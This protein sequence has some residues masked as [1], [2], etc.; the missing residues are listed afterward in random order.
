MNHRPVRFLSGASWCAALSAVVLSACSPSR[1]LERGEVSVTLTEDGRLEVRRAGVLVASTHA[2]GPSVEGDD[3]REGAAYAGF[4]AG[5]TEYRKV[6]EVYGFYDF[7]EEFSPWSRLVP[8]EVSARGDRLT[9]AFQQGGKGEASI[10][11]DGTVHLSWSVPEGLGDRLAMSFTCDDGERFF[12]LGAQVSAEH[13]GWRVPIWTSEQGIGKADRGRPHAFGIAGA[14]YDSYAPIPFALT[15]RPLGMWLESNHRSEFELCEEGRAIRIEATGPR[16]ELHLF[17]TESMADAVEAFTART[18]RPEPVSR[19]T[20]APWVDTFGGP[21]AI[22]D[23]VEKLREHRIPASALW[24]EDWVGTTPFLDGENLT[25][26]WEEDPSRY[27]DLA[28]TA[29]KVH[30]LGIRFLLYFNPFIPIDT[31]VYR[32]LGAAGGLVTDEEGHELILSFPFGAPPAYF[33]PTSAAGREILWEYQARAVAKGADGWM[34][35]Y[36]E[37]LPWEALLSD[38]RSGAEAHNDYPAMW[39]GANKAFWK[40]ARPDGDYATFTRSGFTG[41]SKHA[42][43]H[44]LGD[45]LTTFD[46]NDGFGSVIPLYLSAGLS[47]IALTHSDVGGYTVL[48]NG[49]RT[50]ELWARW[51]AFEAFTP[52]LRT[53]HA[54]TPARSVQWW[55]N[56]DTLEQ[57]GRY[58]RWHQRLLPFFVTVANETHARGFPTVRPI[59]WG[60]ESQTDLY[61][62]EDQV[63]VGGDLLLAP[64]VEEGATSREVRLPPGKWRRWSDFDAPLAPPESESVITAEAAPEDPLLWVRAGAVLPMLA[65]EFE[66]LAPARDDR[67]VDEDIRLAPKRIERLRFL[68][69]GG[70]TGEGRLDGYDFAS[71]RWQWQG[72]HATGALIAARIDGVALPPCEGGSTGCVDGAFVRLAPEHFDG[73][74][75][76][77][78]TE[79]GSGVLVLNGNDLKGALIEVR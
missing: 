11:E 10:A 75:I 46:R 60:H 13:R 68:L 17:P 14:F 64:I 23:A 79:G 47:G 42:H 12:G 4:A 54:S 15:T 7:H 31:Q 67:V 22:E 9:F 65:E 38:G 76:S 62:V 2:A 58:A 69:V 74:E 72:E 56:E 66:S 73:R 21:Q 57:I 37:G 33:D 5:L 43:V 36:G 20:F 59:W 78:E 63:L 61:D 3:S 16:F 26:D 45:Q 19:W 49:T 40:A 71:V 28:G 55:S 44:W 39:A 1:T 6:T 35:D 34:A 50:Y 29:S 18:G 32:D 30:A 8:S 51:L 24:S 77:L 70:G 27:P 41:I 52:I 25:Y 48:P 53:H